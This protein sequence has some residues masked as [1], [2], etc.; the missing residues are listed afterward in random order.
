MFKRYEKMKKSITIVIIITVVLISAAPIIFTRS[1]FAKSLEFTGTGAIG[2]TIG[3]ITAPFIGI[4]SI[5][6]L[7]FTLKAQLDFNKA[8]AT[9]NKLSHIAHLQSEILDLDFR[10]SFEFDSE[11]AKEPIRAVG[12]DS[13]LYLLENK[14]TIKLFQ[15]KL[16]LSQVRTIAVLCNLYYSLINTFEKD[17]GLLQFYVLYRTKISDFLNGVSHGTIRIIPSIQDIH[18]D[19]CFNSELQLLKDQATKIKALFPES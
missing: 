18:Q 10:L 14:N 19:N 5:L 7:F 9:D 6:L 12:L 13:L 3:G 8:Q 16:L 17:G 1:A 15:A 2:D 4:C 11:G